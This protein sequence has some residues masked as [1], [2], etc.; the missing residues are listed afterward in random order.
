MNYKN[1]TYGIILVVFSIIV[2]LLSMEFPGYVVRGKELPG[3]KFFPQVISGILIIMGIYEIVLG[4]Y[5]TVKKKKVNE[6][7]MEKKEVKE[8][9]GITK[10]G[11]INII[12][13]FVGIV[14]FIPFIEIVGFKLGAFIFATVLMSILGMG[15]IRSL[16]YSAI[17][18]AFILIIFDYLFKIPFPEGIF[19]SL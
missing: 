17:L 12:V 7:E 10:R 19:F 1:I 2:I 5:Q 18:T 4:T 13:V 11:I 3:P 14:L 15:I 6:K 8:K 16:L 9:T